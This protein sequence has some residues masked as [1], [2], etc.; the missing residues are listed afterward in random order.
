[1][2]LFERLRNVSTSRGVSWYTQMSH[3]DY[4]FLVAFEVKCRT[5]VGEQSHLGKAMVEYLIQHT[6]GLCVAPVFVYAAT[7]NYDT[8]FSGEDTF[9]LVFEDL[10]DAMMFKLKYADEIETI[11]V[12]F[13]HGQESAYR[14]ASTWDEIKSFHAMR[15]ELTT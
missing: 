14:E 12:L 4:R 2:L 3:R 1:M 13:R 10:E 7:E 8:D 11:G 9:R 5:L 6:N 15:E